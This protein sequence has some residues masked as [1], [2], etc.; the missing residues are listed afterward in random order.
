[1][2]SRSQLSASTGFVALLLLL[3][4]SQ[5]AFAV[6]PDNASPSASKPKTFDNAS[7]LKYSQAAIGNT[8]GEHDFVDQVGG[9]VRL[10]DYRGKPLLISFVY[11]SCYHIC[12]TITRHLARAVKK[13]QDVLGENSFNVL[14]IGFDAL[15]DTPAA[16]HEFARH[17][18][19]NQSNWK[20]LSGSQETIDRLARKVGFL[21]FSSPKGFD[22]LLQ[23]TLIDRKGKVY[24]QVYDINGS[25]FDTPRLVEPLKQLVLGRPANASL[26]TS[27]H[28]RIRLFCTVYDPATGSYYFDYSLY[29]GIIIGAI[30]LLSIIIWL[31][32]E[33]R[34]TVPSK[35][36]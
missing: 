1:M 4:M 17:Q 27:L 33:W 21:Y 29:V 14:T 20:L 2:I 8:L 16:M 6:T 23:T 24:G 31:I 25:N 12:P 3:S 30:I 7:A 26:L 18:N 5:W 34:R 32:R 19:I 13:A 15:N 35:P 11:T 10:S 28:N 9:S 36:V 22:H